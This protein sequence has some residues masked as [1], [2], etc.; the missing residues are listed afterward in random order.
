MAYRRT[1]F[2]LKSLFLFI[3]LLWVLPTLARAQL[4]FYTDDA[5][6]TDQGKV[7]FEFFDEHDVLQKELYPARHQNNGNFTVN[8][9]VTKRL[10]LDINAP[11][12]T[13]FNSKT[14]PLGNPLGIGDT[15]FGVKY[16]FHD[17]RDGSKLPA[18]AVVFYVEAPTGSTEKQLGSGVVDYWLYSVAQKSLTEKTKIRFNGG[19]LFAGNTS[20]GLVGIETTKGQVFTGNGSI[21]HDFTEKLNLG[22]EVFGGVTNNLQLSKGQLETQIGGTYAVSK[23]FSLAFGILGG[24][25]VASP[26]VG[27]L[28][29]FAYD[30]K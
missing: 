11:F 26:R 20:T 22:I 8:Y 9:G 18:L 16:R 2:A 14:S 10:E 30:F 6:T 29:G 23:Q 15:Q 1:T 25:F 28:L 4:P 12:L 17:E 13:I 5:D 19:I 7:H 24:H 21:T 3:L 27:V